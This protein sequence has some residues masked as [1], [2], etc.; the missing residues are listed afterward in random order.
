MTSLLLRLLL[1]FVLVLNCAASV[2]AMLM[3][4]HATSVSVNVEDTHALHGHHQDGDTQAMDQ[5]L[6]CDGLCCDGMVCPGHI[7]S[8]SFP[9]GASADVASVSPSSTA[10]LLDPND[11]VLRPHIPPF[12]PPAY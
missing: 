10:E 2:S 7:T 3:P 1:A 9:T 8:L 6:F 11:P 4:C 12:R 5:P